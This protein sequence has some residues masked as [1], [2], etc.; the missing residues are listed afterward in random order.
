MIDELNTAFDAL[1]KGPVWMVLACAAVALSQVLRWVPSFPNKFIPLAVVAL[2]TA[3]FPLMGDITV[4]PPT[5]RNPH[6]VMILMGFVLGFISWA[7]HA[8][9]LALLF[10]KLQGLLPEGWLPE[11]VNKTPK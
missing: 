8:A 1:T 7:L 2:P 5:Q 4:F 3:G 11:D 10:K 6:L 9:L